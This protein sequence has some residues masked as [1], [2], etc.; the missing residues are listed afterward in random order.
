MNYNTNKLNT[1][2]HSH[3]IDKQDSF[4]EDTI[5]ANDEVV[6]CG[7][8]QS[9][10]LKESWEYMDK[11]HCS[12]TETLAFVPIQEKEIKAEKK[13]YLLFE[14]TPNIKKYRQSIIFSYVCLF[15]CT[16]AA[17]VVAFK[18]L[19]NENLEITEKIIGLSLIPLY[20]IGTILGLR[21]FNKNAKKG[22][23]I[24]MIPLQLYQKKVIVF[25]KL[26]KWEELEGI[27]YKANIDTIVDKTNVP[28]KLEI[29][30]KNE[31]LAINLPSKYP[32]NTKFLTKLMQISEHT[33]VDFY[34][35]DKKE[36]QFLEDQKEEYEGNIIL[37]KKHLFIKK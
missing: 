23:H 13:E 2:N 12:Q 19:T 17:I 26:Y 28:N 14:I 18:L 31:I 7:A 29:Y 10:F 6:F 15:F 20:E 5:K 27:A 24:G 1:Q 21:N 22:C 3:I 33:K 32:H 36:Y 16:L 30:V 11:K 35:E 9:V 4:T 34:T 8:C 37:T 25:D